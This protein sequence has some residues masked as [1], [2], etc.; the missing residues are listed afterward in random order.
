MAPYSSAPAVA[1][2]GIAEA[3]FTNTQQRVLGLLFGQPDRSFFANEVITL[4]GSGSGA[5]QRELARLEAAGL[6]TVQRI[7]NQKHFQANRASPIFEPL[8]KIIQSTVGL[9][10][11]LR[12]ALTAHAPKI[13]AAFVYGS[14]AKNQDT[15]ASDVDLMV[16]SDSLSY[17]DLFAALEVATTT[18]GRAVNPTVL[19]SK[20]VA[21]RIAARESFLTRV[22]AQPKIWLIGSEHDLGV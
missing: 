3:L 18:I 20:D 14:V 10:G 12:A 4:A 8:W 5:V 17:A 22:L 16:I 15:A 13:R 21:K 11:P 9:A 2:S 7:G 6:V 1:A 19:S